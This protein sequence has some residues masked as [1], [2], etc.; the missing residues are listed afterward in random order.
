MQARTN[1]A[2]RPAPKRDQGISLVGTINMGEGN[3]EEVFVR[4][5][6]CGDVGGMR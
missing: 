4:T 6:V 5:R 1:S 3:D 2:S